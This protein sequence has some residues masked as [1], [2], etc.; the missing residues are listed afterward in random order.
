MRSKMN[1]AQVSSLGRFRSTTGVISKPSPRADGYVKV[2]INGKLQSIHRLIAIAFELPRD[3]GQTTVDHIDNDPSNN[4]L[5]NLRWASPSEQ[6]RHSYAT[7]ATRKSSAPKQSKPVRGRRLGEGA[8]T[9]YA[10]V[11]EA[12][13]QLGLYQGHVSACS[14]GKLKQ[15]GGFEFEFATPAEP[16]NLE[17]EEWRDVVVE[18]CSY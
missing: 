9:S 4:L 3:E 6:I 14:A 2:R 11:S 5:S 18:S 8:W 15:T 13:R 16:A 12:A 1:I 7:N 10:S 17:G